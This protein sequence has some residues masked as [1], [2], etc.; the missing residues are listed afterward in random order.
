MSES[1]AWAESLSEDEYT[2]GED[3]PTMLKRMFAADWLMEQDFP[4]TQ[5]VVPGLIPE[6]LTLLVAAPKIGKSWMVLGLGLA[7][8]TG[9]HAFGQLKVDKRPVLYLALE[10]GKKRLQSRMRSIGATRPPGNMYFITDMDPGA[11]QLSLAEF[12]EQHRDEA[13]LIILDTLG[14]VMPPAFGNETQY[15]RDYRVAGAL[16][17]SVD[18]VPGSSLMVVHHTRKA[19]ADDFLDSVSGSQGLAGAADTIALLTRDRES[20]QAILQTTSR[21]AQEGSYALNMDDHGIWQLDGTTL[22]E[23][24]RSAATGAQTAGLGDPMV[25][26]IATVNRHPEG[27]K[28]GDVAT[29]LHWDENKTRLYLKRA[30]DAERIARPKRG[31]YTPVTSETSDTFPGSES[32]TSITNNTG[33][34]QVTE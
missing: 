17:A 3:K 27:I 22:E 10:D 6:G 32:Y 29:L 4:P 9:G 34:D 11:L 31:L 26:L 20:K 7:A 19:S 15:G 25:D 30:Y 13:P 1:L 2:P 5:Y 33:V 28:A 8:A 23:S 18:A 14:K 24:A 21:D 12:L 16:K